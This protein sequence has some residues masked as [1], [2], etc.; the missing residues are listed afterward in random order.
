MEINFADDE[1]NEMLTILVDRIAD[2]AGL[3]D[4]DRAMLKRWR[5]AE[6]RLGSDDMDDLVLKVN[7]DIA[8]LT[9]RRS[10]SQIRWRWLDH[11]RQQVRRGRQIA[12]MPQRRGRNHQILIRWRWLDQ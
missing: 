3:A 7:D 4:K 12:H 8:Q 2:E 11:W 5:T 6:M 10:R 9:D 1:V